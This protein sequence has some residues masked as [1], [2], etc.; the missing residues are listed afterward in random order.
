[1]PNRSSFGFLRKYNPFWASLTRAA[2][3]NY[4]DDPET[5][6]SKLRK[7]GEAVANAVAE[8]NSIDI[9]ARDQFEL[10]D[11]LERA[12]CIDEPNLARLHMLRRLGNKAVHPAKEG[13]M[14]VAEDLRADALASL[15]A[16]H[17]L[18]QWFCRSYCDQTMP[19][20]P[21]DA[22]L[23]PEETVLDAEWTEPQQR[24]DLAVREPSRPGESKAVSVRNRPLSDD[25]EI[26][27]AQLSELALKVIQAIQ[28]DPE[29]LNRVLRKVHSSIAAAREPLLLGVLGEFRAGK[30][31]LIN[32]LAGEPL[33]LT[34]VVET[35]PI[36]CLFRRGPERTAQIVFRD[37]HR[38]ALSVDEVNQT[39]SEHR[40]DRAWLST[41]SHL[42]YSTTL[43]GLNGFEIWDTP[44]L[45]GSEENERIANEFIERVTGVL[46]VFDATLLGKASI[47]GPLIRLKETGKKVVAV[48]NQIDGL[49][50]ESEIDKAVQYLAT[51]Y[52]GLIAATV[53]L[54]AKDSL[55]QLVGGKIDS[56]LSELRRVLQDFILSTAEKDRTNRIHRTVEASILMVADSIDC[57]HRELADRLGFLEH[58]RKNLKIAC[59]R[60]L[61]RVPSLAATEAQIAFRGIEQTELTALERR[62]GSLANTIDDLKDAA[63][64]LGIGDP[65]NRSRAE[66]LRGAIE[67]IDDPAYVKEQWGIAAAGVLTRL[68][69][70]WAAASDEAIELSRSAI[71]DIA[72]ASLSRTTS[73]LQ[74][75]ENERIAD[76]A[77]KHGAYAAGVAAVG[78]AAGII[79]GV[80]TWPMLLVALPVGVMAG[81][82]KY[83]DLVNEAEPSFEEASRILRSHVNRRRD[84]LASR[85][86]T[87][88]EPKI[89]ALL[90]ENIC[91]MTENHGRELLGNVPEASVRQGAGLLSWAS[92]RLLEVCGDSSRRPN[93]NIWRETP[94]VVTPDQQGTM[95]LESL[96]GSVRSRLDI[97]LPAADFS[98]T[99]FLFHLPAGVTLRLVTTCNG[100][101]RPLAAAAIKRA[102]GNWSG[103]RK[104]RLVVKPD[105]S[106][107]PISEAMFLTPDS[108]LVTADNLRGLGQRAITLDPHE[109]GHIA[110]QREFAEV[111][112]GKSGR[113][114]KLRVYPL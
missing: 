96:F 3:K 95:R 68:E 65:R 28:Q 91:S 92:A 56:R 103:D 98:L 62:F 58:T 19:A 94:I 72:P 44:G 104:V 21:F 46:W 42:E 12:H 16:A 80:F 50:G 88:M 7:L 81:W 51:C 85:I 75:A 43:P 84:E 77:V 67:R 48:L 55:Q 112:E 31:T 66:W 105:G 52:P 79:A 87:E 45:G 14:P 6:L 41:L 111:W 33:A 101:D 71:P 106:R 38:Q 47:T 70:E 99:P 59:D 82:K 113:H 53:P 49:D 1:M 2:E 34:D 110:A 100:Q 36:P 93:R 35:T 4:W 61:E 54:S 39:L 9:E 83:D 90:D 25:P 29:D 27:L 18:C 17:E 32:A 15:K 114:G 26:R 86:A 107:V 78:V 97:V 74:D 30:S 102:F 76:Q 20:E 23:P 64:M 5:T 10:L 22:P 109:S 8:S 60:L 63:Q 73:I 89:S 69:T 37:G 24:S 40:Q 11:A 57:Y 108:S 13:G